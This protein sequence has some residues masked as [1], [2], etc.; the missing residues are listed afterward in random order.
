MKAIITVIQKPRVVRTPSP[1]DLIRKVEE[2]YELK[3]NV[4]SY[5]GNEVI[6]KGKTW[7]KLP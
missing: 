5:G 1:Y 4:D 3:E 6:Y 2:Q 7:Y